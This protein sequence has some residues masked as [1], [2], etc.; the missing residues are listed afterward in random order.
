MEI[1]IPQT[2]LAQLDEIRQL[3]GIEW[4]DFFG[5]I[6]ARSEELVP[7]TL[8]I[9]MGECIARNTLRDKLTLWADNIK[10][11]M[12]AID[13]SAD[14]I[15]LEGVKDTHVLII[16]NGQSYKDHLDDIKQFQGVKM[17]CEINLVPLLKAGIVPDYVM[18]LDGEDLLCEHL[19]NPI[20][21]KY[22]GRITAILSSTVHPKIIE[23]WPGKMAFI[24]PWL[25][26]MDELKSITKVMQMFTKKTVLRT[27]G[28]V[29][30]FMW[31]VAAFLEAKSIAMIGLDFSYPLATTP[32]LSDT[33][34]WSWLN[35]LPREE[36]LKHYTKKTTP[37]GVEVITESCFSTM[38]GGLI[39]WIRA[40]PEIR[41]IQLSEYSIVTGVGINQLNFKDYLKEQAGG[42]D[43]TK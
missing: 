18:S 26:D 15:D 41:T 9:N 19:E 20:V 43:H 33:Q 29:G 12:T 37:A 22:A 11:N 14:V 17:C 36:I 24:T 3:N 38:A 5:N 13:E 21:E 42:E 6:L 7:L 2:H 39:S 40:K 1:T 23:R 30:S 10:R 31:F 28:N 8:P 32:Y 16:G 4:K 25:D 27:G 34:A 35:H